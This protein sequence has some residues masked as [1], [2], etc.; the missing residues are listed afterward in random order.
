M[1][2]SEAPRYTWGHSQNSP[3]CGRGSTREVFHSGNWPLQTIGP[4]PSM[5]PRQVFISWRT[6]GSWPQRNKAGFDTSNKRLW[7]KFQD[8]MMPAM[9]TSLA[10]GLKQISMEFSRSLPASR[11]WLWKFP[12]IG[13]RDH[14]AYLQCGRRPNLE[15]EW[16]H[17]TLNR[18]GKHNNEKHVLSGCF[19][20]QGICN[21]STYT[22]VLPAKRHQ[23]WATCWDGPILI[24][25]WA[26][27][28]A[29]HCHHVIR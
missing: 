29:I 23:I 12:R 22:R 20:P 15:A 14:R 26:I 11:L 8:A 25:D 19:Y 28:M 18:G 6:K 13:F 17:F 10:D 9:A 16:E 3:H 27:S 24:C 21:L 1:A 7:I 4:S 5:Y 2:P